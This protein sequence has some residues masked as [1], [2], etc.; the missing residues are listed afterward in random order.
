MSLKV[1]V[2]GSGS[3]GVTIAQLL[4][5]S[6]EVLIYTRRQEVLHEINSHNRIGRYS[7]SEKVKATMD[8]SKLGNECRLIFPVIPSEHFRSAIRKLSPHVGPGHIMIHATKGLDTSPAF[9]DATTLSEIK[10][11]VFTMS[12]VISQETSVARIGAMAGPNLAKEILEGQPAAS[13]IASPFD[14]VIKLGREVLSDRLF[15]VY[16]SHHLK[17]IEL[18]GALKNTI[19]IASGV[20]N[21]IG[22]GKNM[23]ALLITRGLREM[24]LI[25]KSVGAAET[26]FFGTAGIGDLIATTTSTKSRNFTFGYK[27][28]TGSTKADIFKDMSEVAEGYRT[29][30]IAHAISKATNLNTPVIKTLYEVVYEG[31]PIKKAMVDLMHTK[32]EEDVDFL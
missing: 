8:L 3:F 32:L 9:E 15:I 7:L 30:R 22:F 21:G 5:K 26:P 4:S 19:A 25:S 16:G 27:L 18:A 2:L 6:Q 23:Q 17:G 28:G 20:L 29:I 14:E 24:I 31:K 11:S 10:K 1:G 12:E 13:V